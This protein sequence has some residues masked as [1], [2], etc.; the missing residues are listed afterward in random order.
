MKKTDFLYDYVRDIID[1]PKKDIVFKDLS[2]ILESPEAVDYT[3]K[4]LIAKLEFID[5]D[6][7]IGIESRGFLFGPMLARHFK[8]PF[9]MVRKKG[10]LPAET[11]SQKYELE[12]G[13]AE[14]E[15]HK[16]SVKAG[17]K[18]LVHDD[19]LATGGSANACVNLLRQLNASVAGFAFLMELDD[20]NGR[21]RLE[22]YGA[23]VH[24][25]LH[26]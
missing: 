5:F 9:H 17:M 4:V 10:K 25:I 6:G 14:L 1:F 20:L 3:L 13:V 26:F 16:D 11:I 24:S 18:L 8:V 23:D 21:E 12:Y 2:P 22:A 15:L 19:L 7:V